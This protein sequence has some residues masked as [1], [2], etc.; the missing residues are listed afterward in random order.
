MY[1]TQWRSPGC[2]A[3]LFYL[4]VAVVA[5]FAVL[6]VVASN[7][8]NPGTWLFWLAGA[9]GLG[10]FSGLC[11]LHTRATRQ[12]VPICPHCGV[13]TDPRF[14]ICRACGRVKYKP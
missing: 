1:R 12:Q 4:G 11:W 8:E 2:L 3:G 6:T 10:V 9:V 14:R 7:M 13:S 5:G